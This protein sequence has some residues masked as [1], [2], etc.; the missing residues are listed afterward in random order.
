[1]QTNSNFDF[2]TDS[3]R[4]SGEL[5]KI[6]AGLLDAA[7]FI[8]LY[9]QAMVHAPIEIINYFGGFNI[10]IAFVIYRSIA[11]FILEGTVGMF[12]CNCVYMS[13]DKEFLRPFEKLL[14][15]CF[16]LVND[17]MYYDK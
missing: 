6:I 11:I 10:L 3:L 4:R 9:Y 7:V 14:A 1:M 5:K 16:I 13:G 8:F 17:T 12:M 15:A 2:K